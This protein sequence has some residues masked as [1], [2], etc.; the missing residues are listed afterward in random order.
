M[1][2]LQDVAKHEFMDKIDLSNAY[3]NMIIESPEISAMLAFSV[4]GKGQFGWKVL[5]Q[6]LKTACS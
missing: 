6:G 5:P 1:P 3:W 4:P 2:I